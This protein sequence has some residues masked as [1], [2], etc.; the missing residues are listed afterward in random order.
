[1]DEWKVGEDPKDYKYFDPY[2]EDTASPTEPR[3]RFI[4]ESLQVRNAQSQLIDPTPP[5]VVAARAPP[6][7]AP[8]KIAVVKEREKMPVGGGFTQDNPLQ[9]QGSSQ[10]VVMVSTQV[11]PGKFGDRKT[12]QKK[13]QKRV[14]GF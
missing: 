13:R 1:M 8:T 14:G 2:G 12:G 10:D 3:R 5:T 9:V 11:E 4:N 7:I 6:L